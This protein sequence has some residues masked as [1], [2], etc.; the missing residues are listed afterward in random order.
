MWISDYINN[1]PVP[2]FQY[3]IIHHPNDFLKKDH[4]NGLEV[5]EGGHKLPKEENSVAKD[6]R[7][8][9]KS[10]RLQRVDES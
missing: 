6:S 8:C 1:Q 3:P 2:R 10:R 7:K 5:A 9:S 4:P